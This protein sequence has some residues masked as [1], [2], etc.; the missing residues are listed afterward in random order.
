ML[1]TKTVGIASILRVVFIPLF[2]FCIKP[3][4]FNHDVIPMLLMFAMSLTNGYVSTMIMMLAP[5][6]VEPYERETA[7]A[8][9]VRLLEY[10]IY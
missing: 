7:G 8:F 5:Q 2:I 9:M 4:W 10:L 1:N 6:L 3:R